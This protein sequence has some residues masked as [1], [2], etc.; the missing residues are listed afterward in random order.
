[1]K[2]IFLSIAFIFPVVL[3]GQVD[4]SI[5]P[6]ASEAPTINIKDSEVFKTSN[7]IT[8]ILSENHKMP[9]VSFE[10][11]MGSTPMTEGS[12]TGLSDLAGSLIMSGTSNQSKDELDAAVDYMGASLNADNNSIRLSCLTKHK[13]NGLSLMSDVLLN[14]NF[15]QSEVDRIV[16]Q[17]ESGLLSTKSDGATMARNVL[18]KVNYPNGHPYGEVM[19]EATLEKI[20]RDAIVEYYKNTFTPNGSYLVVVG[21][22]NREELNTVIA[23]YFNTWK[24]SESY[25]ADLTSGKRQSGNNVYFVNKPG[26]VQSVVYVTYPID[27]DPSH[28]DYLKLKVL[29]GILGGGG[30]GTRLMQN[31][32][33]DKAYTYGCYSR[34]SVNENG[35][36]I[37]AGGNF[38][39][40]VTD[41][42][43][44]Q[45]LIEYGN[46]I[47]DYV[48]D[49]ELNL[50]KT[51]MAGGFARSLESP[52]TVARFALSIIKNELPKD[53]YQTYLK[54]LDAITKEDILLV[55]QK[56][57]TATQCNIVVVGNEEI[58][59]KLVVFDADGKIEKLD[60]FGN[61]VKDRKEAD[62]TADELI[63]KYVKAIAMGSE[64][65]KLAKKLKKIKSIEEVTEFSMEQMPF[66]MKSTRVW[67]KPNI[68]G[69]RMEGNGMV[70]QK[71]YFDGL[72]GTNSNMQTGVSSLT[73]DEIAS[74]NKSQGLIPEM[75][76]A[77]NGMNYELIGI[78]TIDDKEFYVLKTDDG[79]SE[80]FSYFEIET[81]MKVMILSIQSQEG[82]T[83]ETRIS[84][85]D[86]QEANGILFP[87]VMNMSIGEMT[88]AGKV[89][90]RSVNGKINMNLFQ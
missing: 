8:V 6:K 70:F 4:R 50:T 20:N 79:E 84:Y 16:K 48:K 45:I 90:S 34:L 30:F 86:F 26:A 64:G 57:F 31:L 22:I 54:Q 85:S 18:S 9:R 87:M 44:A 25:K 42:A 74:K 43:I 12:M 73:E 65:K 27:I 88:L 49:E 5:M 72:A 59:S 63:S 89:I 69:S 75:G 55:A 62:I 7:G 33:E 47:D 15:P 23:K 39:N 61:P 58:L 13:D 32:R 80:T 28:E 1:M 82:E 21:D 10:L 60:A 71:S 52:S 78:E 46:I 36:T 19:T 40:E 37:S 51:S 68:E 38:R 29:N 24:G 2:K 81:F 66:P 76:Y 83:T 53:Y 14:A 35:S 41:S 56:Y 77:T 3:F 11:V 17:A 67:S